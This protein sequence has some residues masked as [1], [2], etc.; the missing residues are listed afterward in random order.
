MTL[1]LVY[2]AE[3]TIPVELDGL[4]PER[5]KGMPAS[6]VAHLPV[7]WGNRQV[8]LGE[9]FSVSGDTENEHFDFEGDLAGV[10]R[11][12]AAMTRGC[13]R[14]HGN[15][16]RHVGCEM[17]GGRI[18]VVGG[19]GD[20][21]GAEMHGGEIHVRGNAADCVGAAYRGSAKGM[22]GGVIVV[23]GDAG[24]EVGAAMRRGA[25]AVGGSAG[26]M[27]GVNML[28]GTIV[29]ASGCGAQPGT[30]M[31]RGTIVLARMP[32]PEM[33]PTFVHAC[34]YRPAFLPLIFQSLNRCGFPPAPALA[35]AEYDLFSGDMLELG[36]GE[37]LVRA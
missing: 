32:S 31:R 6:D 28:A 15:A 27:V 5:V 3:T 19:A 35:N 34:R 25:I 22:T 13:I 24:D 29:A 36:R 4:L 30:N 21:L 12:G 26:R 20:W 8:P 23:D 11:I 7:F 2:N 33:P 10:H 37:I 1:R 14:I 17:T 18:E 9:L 16:G